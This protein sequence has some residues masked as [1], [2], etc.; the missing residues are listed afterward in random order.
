MAE[1]ECKFNECQ[2][3]WVYSRRDY[4][5]LYVKCSRCGLERPTMPGKSAIRV[6]R[7]LNM[8]HDDR[9]GDV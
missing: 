6:S 8:R 3:I 9:D 7:E 1:N 5:T 4:E 2:H